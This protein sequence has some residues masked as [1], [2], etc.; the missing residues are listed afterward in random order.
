MPVSATMEKMPV[1]IACF[2]LVVTPSEASSCHLL[3]PFVPAPWE[4]TSWKKKIVHRCGRLV[5]NFGTPLFLVSF[6]A[7]KD[8]A[9]KG[10]IHVE[11]MCVFHRQAKSQGSHSQSPHVGGGTSPPRQPC[12]L[13]P[14]FLVTGRKFP[15]RS[16]K[17][18]C[19]HKEDCGKKASL[20]LCI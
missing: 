2:Q 11:N 1:F 13:S 17:E 10:L 5:N 19:P 15:Q 20:S 9:Q 7:L 18:N 14:V 6:A 12:S 4:G 3:S 8:E 16:V